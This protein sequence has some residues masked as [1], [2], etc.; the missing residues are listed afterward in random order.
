MR[1]SYPVRASISCSSQAAIPPRRTWPNCAPT[2]AFL[3]RHARPS[4]ARPRSPRR[5][6]RSGR[7]RG[8]RTDVGADVV[9]SIGVRGRGCVRAAR[10]PRLA[11]DPPGMAAHHLDDGTRLCDSAVVWSRVDRVVATCT[12]VSKP[13]VSV[14]AGEVVVDHLRHADDGERRPPQAPATPRVS[15]PPIGMSASTPVFAIPSRTSA[16]PSAPSLSGSCG[17]C[18]GSSRRGEPAPTSR[19]WT[20]DRRA[21]EHTGPAVAEADDSCPSVFTPWRTMPRITAL[22]PGGRRRR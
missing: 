11:G 22:S 3:G 21:R 20:R 8:A 5:S 9:M 14:R 13:K 7:A 17:R 12:R 4:A 10:H 16:V 15:S 1:V 2:S 6:R 19:R 18:R